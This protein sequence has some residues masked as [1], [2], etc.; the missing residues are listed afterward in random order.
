MLSHYTSECGFVGVARSQSLWA[1]DFLALNDETEFVYAFSTIYA[2]ALALIVSKLP[3]DLRDSSKGDAFVRSLPA[4]LVDELKAQSRVGDGYGGLYVCSFARGRNDDENQRGIL[5]L[6]D[7][8]TR[9]EGFC[10]Q[11][12]ETQVRRIIDLEAM[13]N[14]YA[15]IDLAEVRYGIAQESN[16]FQYLVTQ[17]MHQMMRRVYLETRDGRVGAQLG[18]MAPEVVLARRLLSFCGVHKD[19]SFA[20]EREM[21]ILAYPVNATEARTLTGI[22]SAKAIY[23]RG[24]KPDGARYIVLGESLIP[25]FI[26]DRIIAGPKAEVTTHMLQALYPFPPPYSKSAIPIR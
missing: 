15:W 10:L 8:Y 5:T 26:P 20:D 23:C 6:W 24:H 3:A 4:K 18:D 19:P 12:E 17:L 2:A 21:R 16:E 7:R 1:S 13:R 14:S 9:N 11:F 22:A 25:G